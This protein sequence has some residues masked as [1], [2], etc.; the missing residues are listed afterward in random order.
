[1]SKR[2]GWWEWGVRKKPERLFT[3][4]FFLLT[5]LLL[6]VTEALGSLWIFQYPNLLSNEALRI[7]AGRPT[8]EHTAIVAI[9]PEEYPDFELGRSPLTAARMRVAVCRV[10][11]HKPAV[12][13]VDFDTSDASYQAVHLE[14]TTPIVWARSLYRFQGKTTVGKVLGQAGGPVEQGFAVGSVDLDGTV[15]RFPRVIEVD[16]RFFPTLHW[17]AIELFRASNAA[18]GRTTNSA[19]ANAHAANANAA[20]LDTVE[21]ALNFQIPS[22]RLR[23][24]TPEAEAC[25]ASPPAV[26][27]PDFS[28]KIVLLGGRYD[29]AD[30]HRTAFGE[31]WG[32]ELLA[33]AIEAEA[34]GHGVL[35]MSKLQKLV[36]KCVVALL[37]GF[38]YSRLFAVPA[39]LVAL[40]CLLPMVVFGNVL[41]VWV[42]GYDGMLVPFVLGVMIEL[43]ANSVEHADEAQRHLEGKHPPDPSGP[44]E[45][46]R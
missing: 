42:G 27:S 31:S 37:L 25:G 13:V 32:V 20:P 16:G 10:L 35:R 44:G 17:R 40:I 33:G 11:A 26:V 18:D 36:V 43:L 6:A 8:A 9:D 39:T 4:R 46:H 28:K 2:S 12:L 15:R 5:G 19:T 34:S 23:E 45:P 1:V 21:L 7:V 14:T 41:A 22:Y 38:L 24:L 29:Y 3:L 30:T